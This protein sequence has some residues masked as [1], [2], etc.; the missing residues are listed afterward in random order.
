MCMD[1]AWA[2]EPITTDA[3]D[4]L[5]RVPF[6]DRVAAVLND[7]GAGGVSTVVGLCGPWGSGKTSLLNLVESR[8]GPPWQVRRF[9]PWA[10]SDLSSLL[11]EF[12]TTIASALPPKGGQKARKALLGCARV[13]VPALSTV[14][15]LVMC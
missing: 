1:Q 9:G 7:A 11:S 12:F 5:G 13:A 10:T 14:R 8:L 4:L 2:D 6:A 15:T 3:E